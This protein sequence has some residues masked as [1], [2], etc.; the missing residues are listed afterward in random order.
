[1]SLV[2]AIVVTTLG[3]GI[4]SGRP[5]RW[6]A[7]LGGSI[8]GGGIV[9]MHY[10]GM[11]A[12]ELPGRMAWLPDLVALSVVFGIA[13]GAVTLMV[14]TRRDD[15]RAMFRAALLLTLT[16]FSL[17]F[18]AMGAVETVFDPTRTT[19]ALSLAPTTL[20]IAIAAVTVGMLALSMVGTIVDERF[21]N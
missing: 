12:V 13:F 14:A 1:S 16:I 19:S 7:P 20:A 8:V 17:H 6:R 3:L 10:T 11:A 9:G 21:H 5:G 2:V 15:I 18:T 4:A